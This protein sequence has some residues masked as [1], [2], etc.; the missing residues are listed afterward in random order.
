MAETYSDEKWEDGKTGQ[1]LSR[2]VKQITDLGIEILI[3]L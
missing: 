2:M 1:F 3:L